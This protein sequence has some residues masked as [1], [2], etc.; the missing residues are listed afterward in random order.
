M[1]TFKRCP[2]VLLDQQ[3]KTCE[4]LIQCHTDWKSSITPE[5]NYN[6]VGDLSFGVNKSEGVFEF[7]KPMAMYILSNNQKDIKDGDWVYV[8]CSQNKTGYKDTGIW[9]FIQA[10]CPMP[11]WGT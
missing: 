3:R 2:V 8:D 1:S 10:P 6:S 4:G 5:E 11:F 7:W 9:K